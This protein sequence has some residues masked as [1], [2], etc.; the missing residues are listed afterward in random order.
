[1]IP[2]S[3]PHSYI[4]TVSFH[5]ILSYLEYLEYDMVPKNELNMNIFNKLSFL[6][7]NLF[8]NLFYLFYDQNRYAHYT[9]ILN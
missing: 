1:M 2:P 3:Q 4:Y 7:K 5:P 9:M 6:N 8:F